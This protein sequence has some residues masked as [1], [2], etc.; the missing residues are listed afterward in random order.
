[1][2]NLKIEIEQIESEKAIELKLKCQTEDSL[3]STTTEL[4]NTS[5]LVD[6]LKRSETDLQN[7]VA[8]LSSKVLELEA[9][10]IQ[11]DQ[12]IGRNI[13]TNLGTIHLT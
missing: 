1:M 9:M 8:S 5:K 4:T 3:K 6:N 11:K 10:A 13:N 12:Q 7:Y 2:K